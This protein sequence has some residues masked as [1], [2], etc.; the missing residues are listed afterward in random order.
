MN[1][2]C[3]DIGYMSLNKHGEEICGD[4]VEVVQQK[5]GPTV[6]VLA[7][8]LGSGVKASI[9]STLTAKIVSTMM[10]NDMPVED[11][12][13]TIA[14]TLPICRIR[15]VAYS[16]FTVIRIDSNM[17][18]EIIQYDN[19]HVALLRSGKNVDYPKISEVIDGKII[20][21][22]HIALK[23]NDSFFAFSDGAIH[24]GVGRSL[25]FG[26]QRNEII[27]FLESVYKPEYTA[28]TLSSMLTGKCN[29]LYG[30][31]P[32]DDTTACAVKIRRRQPINFMIG[33]P[34]SANDVSK[35]MSLF[36]SKAGKHI[37][38]G[39]TTS[40]LAAQYLGKPLMTGIPKY[41]DPNIPPTAKIDGVDLVTEGVITINRVLE[42]AHSYLD[43][44]A[45]Y[46]D[47]SI[48]QDGAS[49]IAR[50]LFEEATDIN[51]F[52]GRAVNP[53]H[54]NPNLPIS[55][56]IK[57]RLVEE[58]SGCLTRMGKEIKISYF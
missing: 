2:L 12:I 50:M 34:A 26:W 21:K 27:A 3:T 18:A 42:Y 23:E 35:M 43:D 14:A 49:Q 9:L 10:A 16:T 33:P 48:K 36:F 6:M 28:K 8:G 45:Q 15:Q 5:S 30:G 56:N 20:Y 29:V 44:N 52:V 38:C 11:C 4:H 17:E 1:D 31:E 57:M 37:V 22:S 53:A 54:Q 47:W 46:L 40:T 39:G 55:F 25:N 32:G 19:P 58:L 51:F 7:D 13:C 41:A 24:A